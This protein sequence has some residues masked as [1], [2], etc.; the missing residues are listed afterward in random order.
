M[1]K[2]KTSG[3]HRDESTTHFLTFIDYLDAQDINATDKTK[4]PT[5]WK[6]F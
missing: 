4:L 2:D 1:W 5:I 6:T 3:L